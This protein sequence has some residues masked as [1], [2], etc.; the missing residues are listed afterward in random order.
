MR[1]II[2][3]IYV[4]SM[5]DSKSGG[6]YPESDRWFAHNYYL[7]TSPYKTSLYVRLRCR[8]Q[9]TIRREI[10]NSSIDGC[11]AG[12]GNEAPEQNEAP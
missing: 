3:A 12:V 1:V 6:L 2:K 11:L 8:N 10:P 5:L 9:S 4:E 7:E